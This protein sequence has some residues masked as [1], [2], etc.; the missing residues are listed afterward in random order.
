MA[1]RCYNLRGLARVNCDIAETVKEKVGDVKDGAVRLFKSLPSRFVDAIDPSGG[2]STVISGGVKSFKYLRTVF[3]KSPSR[4]RS[5]KKKSPSNSSQDKNSKDTTDQS[6]PQKSTPSDQQKAGR[7]VGR[8]KGSKNK[9][10]ILDPNNNLS[11]ISDLLSSILFEIKI[12]NPLNTSSIS[13]PNFDPFVQSI[14]KNTTSLSEGFDLLGKVMDSEDEK[15]EEKNPESKNVLK[16]KERSKS[17]KNNEKVIKK[18]GKNVEAV[19]KPKFFNPITK[20]I[21]SFKKSF[22]SFFK[23]YKSKKDKGGG[24]FSS[25][26]TL[27]ALQFGPKLLKLLAG[28]GKSFSF[29]GSAFKLFF[30]FIKFGPLFKIAAA[31]FA[32]RGAIEG[33]K[34]G[35]ILG[36]VKGLVKGLL[37]NFVGGILDFGKNAIG[38]I[39]G[40]FGL[41]ELKEKLNSISFEEKINEIIDIIFDLPRIVTDFFT[42]I[43]GRVRKFF[44]IGEGTEIDE[45]ITDLNPYATAEDPEGARRAYDRVTQIDRELETTESNIKRSIDTV[46]ALNEFISQETNPENQ[47]RLIKNQEDV[48]EQISEMRAERARLI[49]ERKAQS[50]ILGGEIYGR[51]DRN[52]KP[53]L[54]DE[55]QTSSVETFD[56]SQ[57]LMSR[58][59]ESTLEANRQLLAST[60]ASLESFMMAIKEIDD[61]MKTESEE[62]IRQSLSESRDKIEAMIRD[63][64]ESRISLIEQISEAYEVIGKESP[65]F[66][67]IELESFNL[68]ENLTSSLEAANQGLFE[69]EDQLQ[70][71]NQMFNNPELEYMRPSLQIG[72]DSLQ[73]AINGILEERKRIEREL[74]SFAI[75]ISFT[76]YSP[77]VQSSNDS[78]LFIDDEGS[79]VSRDVVSQVESGNIRDVLLSRGYDEEELEKANIHDLYAELIRKDLER[80]LSETGIPVEF[81]TSVNQSKNSNT[82][83]I[84][85]VIILP[86]LTI[87]AN[88]SGIYDEELNDQNMENRPIFNSSS[89]S[90]LISGIIDENQGVFKVDIPIEI[91]PLPSIMGDP[92]SVSSLE[93]LSRTRRENDMLESERSTEQFRQMNINNNPV[94]D[95]STQNS[96]V[97]PPPSPVRQPPNSHDIFYGGSRS[98]LVF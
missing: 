74:D 32:I 8:P 27:L 70:R 14:Q 85:E 36:A 91:H 7:R 68:S 28:I 41:D 80:S 52:Y 13:L 95:A 88:P 12:G 87:T 35:G 29:L 46:T 16:E 19:G 75:P 3:G 2:L 97:S 60:D 47:T 83:S 63:R 25:L 65:D 78:S 4:R 90:N 93:V 58:S 48:A 22:E 64:E 17:E 9:E 6:L 66:R 82:S 50:E 57:S 61:R 55:I 10:K 40:I 84:P 15:R 81:E 94:I 11:K 73:D 21:S 62:S 24:I 92:S 72:I 18:L 44:G 26:M 5:S 77:S 69:A 39:L 59:L 43:M 31:F 56:R 98:Q 86:R 53:S 20:I 79:P 76:P 33:F 42:D 51:E 67:N 37:G 89:G 49:E 38:F 54:D 34:E 23:F 30:R 1:D 45:S 71:L 96:I